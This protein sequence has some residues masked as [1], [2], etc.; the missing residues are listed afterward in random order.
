MFIQSNYRVFTMY[1]ARN[2][3]QFKQ[4]HLPRVQWFLLNLKCHNL[5][6]SFF[7]FTF[8]SSMDSYW[9]R[10]I[11]ATYITSFYYRFKITIEFEE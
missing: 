2:R 4:L 1:E 9:Q 7:S 3:A 6:F 10:V 5:S 11:N 8:V